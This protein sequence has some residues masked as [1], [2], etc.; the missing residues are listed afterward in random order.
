VLLTTPVQEDT[1][2]RRDLLNQMAELKQ[3]IEEWYET[4]LYPH[5]YDTAVLDIRDIR[6]I[7]S[8]D[9]PGLLLALLDCVACSLLIKLDGL[10]AR[11]D[12]ASNYN[13][14]CTPLS[15]N[16]DQMY[17]TRCEVARSACMFVQARSEVTTK[18]MHFG[19]S[20]LGY[21]P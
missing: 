8:R 13:I 17:I 11:L 1:A 6:H 14:S 20:N 7:Q 18:Q 9:Y 12:T 15:L 4:T 3:R 5:I 10:A 19:L 2:H 16:D 21:V